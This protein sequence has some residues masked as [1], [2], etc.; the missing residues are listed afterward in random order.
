MDNSGTEGLPG[1]GVAD[2]LVAVEQPL[3]QGW[4]GGA[5]AGVDDKPGRLVDDNDVGVF[6]DDGELY[7]PGLEIDGRELKEPDHEAVPFL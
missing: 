5:A 2:I 4:A 1:E 3:D 7:L 6:V